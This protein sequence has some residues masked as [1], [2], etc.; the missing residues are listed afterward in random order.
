[1]RPALENIAYIENYLL[2]NLDPSE[3][4]SAKR[5][6]DSSPELSRLLEQQKAIYAAARRQALRAEIQ[7]YAPSSPSFFQRY[8]YWFIGGLSILVVFFGLIAF[9]SMNKMKKQSTNETRVPMFSSSEED[10]VPWIPFDV[11]YFD[12]IAEKGATI[13]GKD[14]TLII[15]GENSLLD[16][17]GQRVQGEVQAEL[18]EAIDWEDM[19]AYNLTTTSSGKALS[20][21]GMMRIRYRQDGKEV[22]CAPEKPMYVEIPTNNYNPEMKVWE[23]EVKDDQLDWKNPQEIDRYLRQVDLRSLDFVPEGF[24]MEVASI[25][26]YKGHSVVSDRLVDSLYY[27]ISKNEDLFSNQEPLSS[28]VNDCNFHIPVREDPMVR[29]KRPLEQPKPYLKGNN[30]V[31]G[32]IVDPEGNPIAGM[33]VKLRMDRYLENDSEVTTDD[34]GFFT[35]DKFYPGEVAIYA[36]LHSEDDEDIVWKYCLATTFHCPKSPKQ[37]VLKKPLVAEYSNMVNFDKLSET[38]KTGGSFIDPLTIKTL[39]TSRFQNTFIATREFEQRLQ[40]MHT[41]K[42]GQALLDVYISNLSEPLWKCDQMAANM[43]TGVHRRMFEDFAQQRLTNVQNDGLHHEAL[44]KYYAQQQEDFREERQ[45][46]VTEYQSKTKGEL[47]T[48]MHEIETVLNDPNQL[49]AEYTKYK[50]R[51]IT[52][53]KNVEV[54]SRTKRRTFTTDTYSF[55]WASNEWCNIDVYLRLLGPSPWVTAIRTNISDRDVTVYRTAREVQSVLALKD[56]N[57]VYNALSSRSENDDDYC[58]ALYKKNDQLYYAGQGFEPATTRQL[59]LQLLPVTEEEFYSNLSLL[60]PSE[61]SLANKL[62][63]DHSLLKAQAAVQKKNGQLERAL[64]AAR[65]DIDSDIVVYNRLFDFLNRSDRS[66]SLIQ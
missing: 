8:R 11:Q 51:H 63:K 55:S 16:A 52:S 60:A 10:I 46:R 27:S 14:G 43:L 49:A 40:I 59:E 15:L 19:L 31:K 13:I 32:Q 7:S 24:D 53:S 35:F 4:E 9:N 26:P 37:F 44:M 3:Q 65:S 41:L 20:S 45:Q 22:F 56:Q 58:V 1:M 6:I 42:K 66:F 18:I 23:G 2:G 12:L 38:P 47:T 48:L 25:L 57:G 17:E 29:G 30:S 61:S 5:R 54:S 21:G 34:N 62:R 50:G 39:K 28:F 36:S 33:D 64:K